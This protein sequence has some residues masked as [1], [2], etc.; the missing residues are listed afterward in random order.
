MESR[1]KVLGHP[2]HQILVMFP[3]GALGFAGLCDGAYVLTRK[4]HWA[5]A[6]RAA[7]GATI[8]GATLAAPFGLI[9]YLAIPKRTRARTVGRRHGIGNA[10]VAGLLVASYLLRRRK[11]ASSLGRALSLGGL[12]LAGATAWL[13]GELVVRLGIGTADRPDP[14]ASSSLGEGLVSSG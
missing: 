6:A 1:A 14:N 10:A 13:G 9:D 2:V 11:P 5:L 8:V 4:R 12:A 3:I 7:V